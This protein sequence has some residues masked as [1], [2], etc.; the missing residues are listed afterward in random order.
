MLLLL[1]PT[2]GV[3]FGTHEQN[4]LSTVAG[5]IS[6]ALEN[7]QLAEA[8][9]AMSVEKAELARR[10]F[11]DPLTQIANRSLFMRDGGDLAVASWPARSARSR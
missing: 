2:R 5:L 10:A 4:L 3:K 6:V 1:N 9:K 7:G 11:Y 8:I